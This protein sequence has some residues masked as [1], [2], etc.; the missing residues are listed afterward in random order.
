M[1]L[2]QVLLHFYTY[3]P[4][5]LFNIVANGHIRCKLKRFL[6]TKRITQAHL[7]SSKTFSRYKMNHVKWFQK[8]NNQSKLISG[9]DSNRSQPKSGNDT[10][11]DHRKSTRGKKA[12]YKHRMQCRCIFLHQLTKLQ[13]VI[14]QLG[15]L[16]YNGHVHIIQNDI[17]SILATIGFTSNIR[18]SQCNIIVSDITDG[19]S[20]FI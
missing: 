8:M 18:Q 3:F 20:V 7:V 2:T 5:L 14:A 12:R 9:K 11:T 13:F 10:E 1:Q 15:H 4:T 6:G 17:A 19:V 16:L